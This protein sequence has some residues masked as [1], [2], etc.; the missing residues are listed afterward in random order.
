MAEE[1]IF[2]KGMRFNKPRQ[3]SP[4]FVRGSIS[5]KVDEAIEFLNQ[6]K[7]D[8]GY[9][10]IDMLKSKEKG[11]IY[12]VLNTWQPEKKDKPQDNNDW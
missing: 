12:M 10:N 1:K 4:E 3:G 7:N 8:R 9:V 6:Y 5:F 11:E 2:P